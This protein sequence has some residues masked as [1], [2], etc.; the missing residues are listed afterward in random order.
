MHGSS[1]KH[2]VVAVEKC[3]SYD[4]GAVRKA[5]E[6]AVNTVG[7]IGRFVSAGARVLVKPNLLTAQPPEKAITTHPA[8]LKAVLEILLEAGARPFVGDSPSGYRGGLEHLWS[9]TGLAPV[10]R[11]LGVELVRF[12]AETI[13][14]VCGRHTLC[15]ARRARDADVIISL[16]KF[17]THSLTLLTCA[18]KNMF[19]V[20]PGYSKTSYHLNYPGPEEFADMLVSVYASARPALSIVDAVVGMEGNGPGSGGRPRH[21]GLVLAGTDA[22]ALD[23]VGAYLMGIPPHA[24]L[25]TKLAAKRG[26]G[27]SD[28][29]AIT[30]IGPALDDVRPAQ[31]LLPF[32]LPLRLLP[33]GL[34]RIAERLLW[35]RPSFR[36]NCRKCGECSAKCPAGAIRLVDRKPTLINSKCIE[37]L[38]CLEACPYDAIA[39]KYSFLAGT[40]LR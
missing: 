37:C 5:V 24:V 17:K 4:P 39:M 35:I 3:A 36:P 2:S 27:E 34:M 12:E 33:S 28:M 8:V 21:V 15:L 40:F 31:Y 38:C 1:E 20:V 14:V 32:G 9:K 10:C 19:G 25:T 13:S 30:V 29:A 6:R 7:G 16:P 18:I 22:I 26:L 23:A 11:E